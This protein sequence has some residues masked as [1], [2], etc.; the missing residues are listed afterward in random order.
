M[1]IEFTTLGER[2]QAVIPKSIR[3]RMPAPRGTM[4]SVV[5]IDKD[6]L[7]MRRFDKRKLLAEFKDLRALIRQKF[8]DKEIV[9]EIK[10]A[11]KA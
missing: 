11:R 8:S 10:R 9:G 4:F 2:G 5:L 1:E 7:V 6:T 3:D